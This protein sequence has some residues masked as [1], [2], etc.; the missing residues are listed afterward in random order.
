M[1]ARIRCRGKRVRLADLS[2]PAWKHIHSYPPVSSVQ[3]FMHHNRRGKPWN[4]TEQTREDRT[5]VEANFGATR[6]PS[7]PS[8]S[9]INNTC[10][11]TDTHQHPHPVL[12]PALSSFRFSRRKAATA[13]GRSHDSPANTRARTFMK[14]S[15]LSLSLSVS[16]LLRY[17]Y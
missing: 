5:N 12:Y 4:T 3:Y 2:I 6:E 16:V 7:L 11:R 15:S 9:A 1:Y 10:V 13:H 8:L 14:D 17:Y